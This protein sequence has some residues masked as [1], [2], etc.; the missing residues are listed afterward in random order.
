[1][2]M[3][4]WVHLPSSWIE[5]GGLKNFQW[6]DGGSDNTAGLM[7]LIAI[8]HKAD[9]ETGRAQ[10]TYNE[11]CTAIDISRAK[12]S[13]GLGLLEQRTII[14]RW[15]GGRSSFQLIGYDRAGG[16]CKLPAKPLYIGPV[17][18]AFRHFRLRNMVE[19]NAIRLYLLFAARRGRDTNLANIS[20]DRITKSTGIRRHDIKAAT[21]FLASLS[22]SYVERVPSNI[23]NYGVSN[24]YRLVGLETKSHM[25][26]TGRRLS[27]Y[28]F[29]LIDA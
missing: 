4:T 16:W 21:S 8:A 13:K 23:N 6:K 5:L 20:F 1:M 29:D 18:E 28:E 15:Q 11:L 17:I 7:A 3:K 27:A 25:G 2:A 26:T 12:L 22:L 19:L 10:V 24:A 14:G 9:Q